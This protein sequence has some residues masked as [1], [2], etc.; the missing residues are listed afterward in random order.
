[1]YNKIIAGVPLWQFQQLADE[2]GVAH[3]IS[4]REGEWRNGAFRF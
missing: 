1:M 2:E 3:Y 4:G